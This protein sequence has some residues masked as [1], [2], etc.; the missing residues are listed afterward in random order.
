MFNKTAC[1]VILWFG[2]QFCLSAHNSLMHF[3]CAVGFDIAVPGLD[4]PV[5][6]FAIEM[7]L[8]GQVNMHRRILSLKYAVLLFI[9]MTWTS[10]RSALVECLFVRMM[11][12]IFEKRMPCCCIIPYA[13]NDD[14]PPR[15]GALIGLFSTSQGSDK[16]RSSSKKTCANLAGSLQDLA[17]ACGMR[18]IGRKHTSS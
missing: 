14:A 13:E 2:S 4:P 1:P 12:H 8:L 6:K 5:S 11:H 17:G 3:L 16:A 18:T 15:A 7:D 10:P 9:S